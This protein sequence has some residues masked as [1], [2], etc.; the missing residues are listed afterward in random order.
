MYAAED[1]AY[2]DD[3]VELDDCLAHEDGAHGLHAVAQQRDDEHRHAAVV[4]RVG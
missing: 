1:V 4:A 3:R 2:V